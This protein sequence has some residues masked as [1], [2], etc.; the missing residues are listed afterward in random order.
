MAGMN[1]PTRKNWLV[2]M[3]L[4]KGAR[5]SCRVGPLLR[6]RLLL[7][8]SYL[9]TGSKFRPADG[10]SLDGGGG[11]VGVGDGHITNSERTWAESKSTRIRTRPPSRR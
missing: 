8:L 2:W 10:M 3:K 6:P 9:C 7:Q 5:A 11:G 4:K 1:L